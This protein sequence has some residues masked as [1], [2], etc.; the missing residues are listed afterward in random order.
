M[1]ASGCD[2]I[3]I[4]DLSTSIDNFTTN[5]IETKIYPNPSSDN[6]T[7]SIKNEDNVSFNFILYNNIG[8]VVMENNSFENN[9]FYFSIENYSNGIY[10]YNITSSNN[11][12]TSGKLIV[13]H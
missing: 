9:Q 12:F 5:E 11:Q 8:Q 2:T 13:Q 4:N 10:Y 7:I 6:V 3:H 1:D